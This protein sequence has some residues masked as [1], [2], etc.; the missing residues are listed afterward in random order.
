MV[1][2]KDLLKTED[3]EVF[4]DLDNTTLY[5][6]SQSLGEGHIYVTN[7]NVHWI[8][9]NNITKYTFNFYSIGLNAVFSKTDEFP[10]SVY[11]QVDEIVTVA[12]NNENSD[13]IKDEEDQ[14]EDEENSGDV[15]DDVYTEI[16]FI[17]SDD[18]KIHSIYDALC[19]GALLNPDSED[20]EEGDF[21]YGDGDNDQQLAFDPNDLN[22][23][24]DP[25][26]G[27]DDDEEN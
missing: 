4:F 14:D 27:D 24:D 21:Y 12:E 8:S 9:K 10:S 25:D 16:R 22:R 17:P 18:S 23:F 13:K 7:K 20:D 6:G 1:E 15:D 26:D 2:I 19:K 5:I 11:C 3:E